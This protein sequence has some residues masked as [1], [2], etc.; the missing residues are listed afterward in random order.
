VGA[1]HAQASAANASSLRTQ[2]R[3]AGCIAM[4]RFG[5]VAA[6][7]HLV[8]YTAPLPDFAHHNGATGTR[9]CFIPVRSR[10]LNATI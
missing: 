7:H 3:H 4:R 6:T 5:H 1:L 8:W 9:N 2:P 10:F